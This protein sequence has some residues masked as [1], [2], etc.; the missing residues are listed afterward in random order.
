MRSDLIGPSDSSPFQQQRQS[1]QQQ[2]LRHLVL[3]HAAKVGGFCSAYINS[4]PSSG[5]AN[6]RS[7]AIAHLF[8]GSSLRRL[9]T[10]HQAS[11]VECV[12]ERSLALF[13]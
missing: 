10:H 13:F 9:S 5:G 3:A 7:A 2:Q 6:S 11:P 4:S 1:H 12:L 8:R